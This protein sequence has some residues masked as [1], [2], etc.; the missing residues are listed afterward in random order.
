M[1]TN[2]KSLFL[3]IAA[4]SLLGVIGSSF[5]SADTTAGE[6]PAVNSILF[7][8][9]INNDSLQKLP[10]LPFPLT[11]HQAK[12]FGNYLVVTGGRDRLGKPVAQVLVARIKGNGSIDPWK[13]EEPLSAPL[14]GHAMD[15]LN[16][17]AY[18]TGGMRKTGNQETISAMTWMCQISKEGYPGKWRRSTDMPE[19]LFAHCMVASGNSLY[20]IGGSSVSGFS[21]SV[22]KGT[23]GKD[24]GIISW[25]RILGIPSPLAYFSAIAINGYIIVVGGQSPAEGKTLIMPTTYVGPLM[26][27]GEPTTWY[28]ASSRLPGAWLGYGR[29][30]TGI[31]AYKDTIFCIGGQDSSWFN[32][33]NVASTSF[34]P[35]KGEIQPWGISDIPKGLQQ[36]SALA[37]WKDRIYFIGGQLDGKNTS[38]VMSVKIETVEKDESM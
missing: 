9:T 6:N 23:V 27:D 20:V 16:G 5:S 37:Q 32:I 21:N 10:G 22:Y 35:D 14:S 2:R 13:V 19:G 17:Y 3:V 4:L 29:C 12:V 15:S 26:K 7:D 34:I 36:I 1:I 24:G 25:K 8:S 38:Q 31:V 18:M 11:N 30:Q 33:N 28:L